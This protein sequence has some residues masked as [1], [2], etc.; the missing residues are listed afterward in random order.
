MA[1]SIN[2]SPQ[3]MERFDEKYQEELP[4]G[5]FLLIRLLNLWEVPQR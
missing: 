5:E 1:V 4:K 2:S 3:P